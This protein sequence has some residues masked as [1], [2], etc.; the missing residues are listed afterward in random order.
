MA[1]ITKVMTCYVAVS[2]LCT[3]EVSLFSWVPVTKRA[4]STNGTSAHLKKGEKIRVWDLLH[5]LML[6]SGN[7]AA[8]CIAEYIGSKML[9]TRERRHGITEP[10]RCF[11]SEMNAAAR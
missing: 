5:A 4:A 9:R 7:D 2:Y 11:I 3:N 8:V 1:S 6:P 10:V